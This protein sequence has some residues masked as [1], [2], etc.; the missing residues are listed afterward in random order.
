M[1]IFLSPSAFTL[2]ARDQL[3]DQSLLVVFM[4]AIYKT[5]AIPG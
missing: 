4:H 1:Y 5:V 3:H 2:N